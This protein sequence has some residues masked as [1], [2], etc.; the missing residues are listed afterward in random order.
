MENHT[1]FICLEQI[2][3]NEETNLATDHKI[4]QIHS[5]SII[6]SFVIISAL[7]SEMEFGLA[8]FIKS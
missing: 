3:I 7:L 5:S 2:H 6:L 1:G 8:H 4:A